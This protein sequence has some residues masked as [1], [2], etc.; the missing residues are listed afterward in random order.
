MH[1][2]QFLIFVCLSIVLALLVCRPFCVT[3]SFLCYGNFLCWETRV[4][5]GHNVH[6]D[7]QL[8]S[9]VP[10]DLYSPISSFLV[11]LCAEVT[12]RS[13]WMFWLSKLFCVWPL[14]WPTLS[15]LQHRGKD[16][17]LQL[18]PLHFLVFTN[19]QFN[20][21]SAC[22]SD[23]DSVWSLVATTQPSAPQQTHTGAVE[24]ECVYFVLLPW[25]FLFLYLTGT[26]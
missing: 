25:S 7:R 8:P 4:F 19:V 18:P 26:C 22:T 3:S 10:F 9:V 6:C 12:F 2:C 24:L 23:S 17:F 11:C 15:S 14:P 5:L 21:A 13:Y 16:S 1:N 20:S